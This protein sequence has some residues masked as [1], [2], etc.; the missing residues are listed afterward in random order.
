VRL[1]IDMNGPIAVTDA[2]RADPL[3][4]REWLVREIPHRE[5][6]EFIAQHHYAR[7]AANTS[8]ARY[9][10]YH[11]GGS[12]LLGAIIYMPPPGQTAKTADP[13]H[14]ERVLALS[15]LAIAPIAPRN[16]ASHLISKSARMLP[17]RYETIATW[18]DT[19]RGHVGTI[20]H[21]A[22][23]RYHGQTAPQPMFRDANGVMVSR[24]RGPKTYTV[25]EMLAMGYQLV[26]RYAR[27]K[28]VARRRDMHARPDRPY[29]KRHP[30]LFTG[31]PQ[32]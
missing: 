19:A 7:G 28:Y 14:P 27:H 8:V 15:R 9:G 25:N 2:P 5:A 13:K 20:Y 12:E 23:W 30:T 24:K 32:P 29:P 17:E 4:K 1:A 3:D 26:G 31:A 21:A 10:L 22:N 11:Q 16:A 18:A 6:V